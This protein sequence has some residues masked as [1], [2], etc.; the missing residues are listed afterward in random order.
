M[1]CTLDQ[2]PP[3]LFLFDG[4]L[5]FKS[6]YSTKND[7]AGKYQCD[8]FVVASGE[9]FWGGT[10]DVDAR[11]KL[12]VEPVE[13]PGRGEAWEAL[14]GADRCAEA[15]RK[16]SIH[17]LRQVIETVVLPRVAHQIED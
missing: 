5:G 1:K 4:S 7:R 10:S 13:Q 17:D 3:G 15:R 9:Y 8:A 14:L 11:A 2:C 16:T 12:I 6:E